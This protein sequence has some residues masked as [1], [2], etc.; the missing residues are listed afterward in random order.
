MQP[1]TATSDRPWW[2]AALPEDA[3]PSKGTVAAVRHAGRAEVEVSQRHPRGLKVTHSP[4]EPLPPVAH[5]P[6]ARSSRQQL[7]QRLEE[8]TEDEGA[9]W[10]MQKHGPGDN[11]QSAKKKRRP[12]PPNARGR[13]GAVHKTPRQHP[14]LR[15]QEAQRNV[16]LTAVPRKSARRQRRQGKHSTSE[17]KTG[18]RRGWR[19]VNTTTRAE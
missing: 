11:Q 8:E 19:G 7:S 2:L 5:P 6:A 10:Q 17:E 12:R 13:E 9:S 4:R 14:F 18:S 15:Q 1:Q 3:E 16:R